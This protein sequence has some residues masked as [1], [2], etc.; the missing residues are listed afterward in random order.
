MGC[1]VEASAWAGARRGCARPGARTHL[2][3]R[4]RAPSPDSFA[5][6]GRHHPPPPP[7]PPPPLPP[8]PPSPPPSP[9]NPHSPCPLAPSLRTARLCLVAPSISPSSWAPASW[10]GRRLGAGVWAGVG[11]GRA[12]EKAVGRG[13]VASKC[14]RAGEAPRPGWA[15]ARGQTLST[16]MLYPQEPPGLRFLVAASA[17]ATLAYTPVLKRLPLGKNVTVA[18][19]VAAALAAGALATGAV[20]GLRARGGVGGVHAR[21]CQGPA[22]I[23]PN[24][25][26]ALLS[27]VPGRGRSAHGVPRRPLRLPGHHAAR[28]GGYEGWWVGWGWCEGGARAEA[29]AA[30]RRAAPTLHLPHLPLSPPPIPFLPPPPPPPP[31]RS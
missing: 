20:S 10:Q 3:R 11:R 31:P 16:P 14:G 25:A 7:P 6:P 18:A 27:L 28:G 12:G 17:A 15:R 1:G 26:G 24:A 30:G 2:P 5:H 13:R 22:S 4:P 21:P 9:P 29:P 23:P 19:V 8:P